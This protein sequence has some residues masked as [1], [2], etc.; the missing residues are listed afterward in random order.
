MPPRYYEI[1]DAAPLRPGH[2]RLFAIVSSNYFLDGIIFSIAPLTV[3][4]VAASYGPLVFALNL[5]S[6]TLGAV[7]FGRF[8]D[9]FGRRQIFLAS[10]ILEVTALTA[11]YF[12]YESP[13][14]LAL[15]TSIAT[16]GIGGEFGAA[17]SALAELSPARHR[18]KMIL[19]STNF[20][21]IG[22][23]FIAA[24]SLKYAAIAGDPG[25]QVRLLLATA[26][27]TAVVVGLARLGFPE[28]PRWLIVRGRSGEAERLVRHITGFK[29]EVSLEPPPLSGI[30]LR[31][32]FSRY[33]FRL[34]VLAVVTVA[35]YV[36]YGVAAYYAPYARGFSF[37]VESAPVIVLVANAGASV[38]ALP[39]ALLID[40]SRRGALL[41]SFAAG[42]ATAAA[43][44][45]LH[46]AGIYAAYLAVLFINLFFSE[47][48]W[49]SI[50]A[51]QSELFP[52]GVRASLVGFLVG[53][54]GI[55][56]AAVVL[57]ESIIPATTFLALSA[58][59]W[60]SGLIASLAWL[61]RGVE[62]A[63]KSVEVLE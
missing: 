60:L 26:L 22:A 18:G 10:L 52:T 27:G 15:F 12:T 41:A 17:Y 57:V 50:S 61:L 53:L 7:I 28:S 3:Y 5:L 59:L 8:S 47:W 44:V 9:R 29:G 40:K 54:T 16:F 19:L 21:N 4:L 20:W 36:T 33:R 2:L 14:A 24:L 31:Q 25:A 35:Q 51:L 62:S 55:V 63:S 42:A 30:G 48:A 13:V 46:G 37:G 6:E 58:T 11:L 38:G 43:M 23:A 32:A 56:G 45:A 34:T 1:L 39:L 49:G